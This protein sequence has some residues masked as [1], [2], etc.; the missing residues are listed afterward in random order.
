MRY[1]LMKSKEMALPFKASCMAALRNKAAMVN[2][3]HRFCISKLNPPLFGSRTPYLSN[4]GVT[5]K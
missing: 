2:D 3:V 4:K 5:I 1:K